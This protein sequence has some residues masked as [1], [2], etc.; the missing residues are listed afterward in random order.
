MKNGPS[1]SVVIAGQLIRGRALAQSYLC[2]RALQVWSSTQKK[3]RQTAS[4]F[5]DEDAIA[6]RHYSVL[7]QMNPGEVD[8]LAPEEIEVTGFNRVLKGEKNTDWIC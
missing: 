8:G 1:V 7:N 3:G 4:V 2:V 5:A 6:V